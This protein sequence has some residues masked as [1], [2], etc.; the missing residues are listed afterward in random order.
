MTCK[1]YLDSESKGS[2][3]GQRWHY[4][5]FPSSPSPGVY[6]GF[7]DTRDTHQDGC[8]SEAARQK[9]WCS[10]GTCSEVQ[11]SGTQSTEAHGV[12]LHDAEQGLS[13]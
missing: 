7:V 10:D 11:R 6:H 8:R 3:L 2:P 13:A 5:S 4:S 12:M 1:K 9:C